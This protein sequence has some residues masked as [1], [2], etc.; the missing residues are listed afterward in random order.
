LVRQA[1]IVRNKSEAFEFVRLRKRGRFL[2]DETLSAAMSMYADGFGSREIEEALAVSS[3]TVIKL[4]KEVGINRTG[5]QA[6]HLYIMKTK[7]KRGFADQRGYY[8]I[9]YKGRKMM[10][11]R[12]VMEQML[13]RP[14]SPDEKVHHKNG[15][16]MDNRPENLE[17]W[18]HH[19]PSGQR[20]EDRIRDAVSLLKRYAPGKLRRI[21]Q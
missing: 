2:P 17:L 8:R 11:H 16:K 1:K 19:Q 18:L 12:A 15:D 14:V 7:G 21:V 5:A 20:V 9:T 10:A 4:A 6:M 3:T 13:G